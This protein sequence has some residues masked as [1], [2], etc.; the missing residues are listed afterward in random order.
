MSNPEILPPEPTAAPDPAAPVW[1]RKR[2]G[3]VTAAVVAATALGGIAVARAVND[4]P[5]FGGPGAF[6]QAGPFSH[7]GFPFAAMDPATIQD[8]ADKAVRHFAI[9][10]DATPEQQEKLRVIVHALVNDLLPLRGNHAEVAQ[11]VRSLLTQ[12]TID[13]A[14]IE[15]LRAEQIGKLDTASKRITQAI[16]EAAQ[17]LT[18]EQRLKVAERMPRP[19]AGPFWR[20]R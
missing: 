8:R 12:Q 19:G 1:R 15:K 6:M 9:E 7:R 11:R 3:L 5:Q 14:A 17:V 13:P 10:V 4:P 16:V 20:R 2:T 18:P